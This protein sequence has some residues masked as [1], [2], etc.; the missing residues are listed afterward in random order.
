[1]G[2]RSCRIT[3]LP[4]ILSVYRTNP[5]MHRSAHRESK[6]SCEGLVNTWPLSLRVLLHRA[7]TGRAEHL[8]ATQGAQPGPTQPSGTCNP[9]VQ[10]RADPMSPLK[11]GV[12]SEACASTAFRTALAAGFCSARSAL[13]M[14][15]Y[16]R[17]T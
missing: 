1:M 7:P 3:P 8:A 17:Q 6:T 5:W 13:H 15:L 11:L 10:P 4:K 2:A 12:G 16:R 9:W 14:L